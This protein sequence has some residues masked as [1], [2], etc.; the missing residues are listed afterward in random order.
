VSNTGDS[1]K[2]KKFHNKGRLASWAR[3]LPRK[4]RGGLY[5]ENEGEAM[6]AIKKVDLTMPHQPTRRPP[7]L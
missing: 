4:K 6:E 1:E 2:F 7:F 3:I 5:L